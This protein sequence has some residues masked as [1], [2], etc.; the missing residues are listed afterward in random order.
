MMVRADNPNLIEPSEL[1]MLVIEDHP[2][3]F[4]LIQAWVKKEMKGVSIV[5]DHFRSVPSLLNTANPY[6]VCFFH[7]YHSN[8]FSSQIQELKNKGISKAV[9]VLIENHNHALVEKAYE[10]GATDCI[11]LEKLSPELVSRLIRYNLTLRNQEEDLKKIQADLIEAHSLNQQLLS[12]ITS[13]LIGIHPDGLVHHWNAIAEKTFG[14]SSE[15]ILGKTLTE[16]SIP[17]ETERVRVAVLE[18][19]KKKQPIRLDDVSFTRINGHKGFLGFTIIPMKDS[20]SELRGVLLFGA[21]I[22]RRKEDEEQLRERTEELAVANT[23]L[24]R[25]KSQYQTLLENIG[26]GMIAVSYEGKIVMMNFQAEKMLGLKRGEAIGTL[27]ESIVGIEDEKGHKITDEERPL[28]SAI[29]QGKRVMKT[30]YYIKKDGNLFPVSINV[31]PVIVEGKITGAIEI[32]RDITKQMEID[33]LKSEFIST[34]SH[35]LRTPLTGIREGVGQVLEGIFGPINHDQ[36]EFLS[37]ALKEIQR[38][39]SIVNDLLDMSKIEAG[40]IEIHAKK[41]DLTTLIRQMEKGYQGLMR[42]K[43]LT[44]KTILPPNYVEI[45]A[46]EEKLTQVITNLISNAYKFTDEGG[47]IT[48]ELVP[49]AHEVEVSVQDTGQ[50]IHPDDLNRI[51]ERFVQVGRTDGPGMKGTGLGLPIC[52][53]L[54]EL[55]KGKMW[56]ESEP[57]KGSRF[58]FVVP[59]AAQPSEATVYPPLRKTA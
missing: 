54:I 56:A 32:F 21:D 14:V 25:E 12:S 39:T 9:I 59:F 58:I 8:S 50:G 47:Q 52:K 16:S 30:A 34:V 49:R 18:C 37:I 28:Y 6:D 5:V 31:S 11:P 44:L 17:W 57:G 45:I 48:I 13:I 41:I 15:K 10:A 36:H 2:K 40:K 38:L 53:S 1:R 7:L 4:H 27:F 43:Q 24:A 3:N 35:E 20:K 42:T 22:T 33:R 26:D 55:H 19:L 29:R 23:Q 51:F 46:D